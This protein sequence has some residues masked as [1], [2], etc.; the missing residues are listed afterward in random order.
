MTS[1]QREFDQGW[2][3]ARS[4]QASDEENDLAT[5]PQKPEVPNPFDESLVRVVAGVMTSGQPVGI[6][7]DRNPQAKGAYFT[8]DPYPTIHL[9]VAQAERMGFNSK[10]KVWV[11]GHEA[12]HHVQYLSDPVAYEKTFKLAKDWAKG[13]KNL[14]G[15]WHR[16]FNVFLDVHV[17]ALVERRVAPFQKGGSDQDIP[18]E[19]YRNK[20]FKN[21]GLDRGPRC[22]QLIH[23]L[24]RRMMVPDEAV[25]ITP[26]VQAVIDQPVEFMGTKYPSLEV[27]V[28]ERFSNADIPLER[29]VFAMQHAIK[30]IFEKLL[31]EDLAE[32]PNAFDED[33]ETGAEGYDPMSNDASDPENFKDVKKY[34]KD[35]NKTAAE[36][37]KEKSEERIRTKLNAIPELTEGQKTEIVE[38]SFRM[39]DTVQRVK[40]MWW[41]LIQ[42]NTEYQQQER[43]G[44]T[45]G[46]DLDTTQVVQQL[47]TLLTNPSQAEIFQRNRYEPQR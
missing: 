1:S 18:A 43:S 35:K 41:R 37:A 33:A 40:K 8:H 6:E 12:G 10:E 36:R 23:A 20:L 46:L 31:A 30:P 5:V 16:F 9:S 29:A 32:N 28:Q 26:E 2:S 45:S 39:S 44:F 11:G 24:L 34:V 22:Y 13:D 4:P 38:R 17:N 15:V 47:P 14:Q 21:E 25:N 7:I 3:M 42:K 19:L 27:L